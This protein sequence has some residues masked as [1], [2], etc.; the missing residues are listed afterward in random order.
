MPRHSNLNNSHNVDDLSE[1]QLWNEVSA[2]EI[3]RS[4]K[5]LYNFKIGLRK[6]IEKYRSGP[7]TEEDYR[8]AKDPLAVR[9]FKDGR[10]S[11][12]EILDQYIL[13]R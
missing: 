4:T 7:M 5:S 10:N 3:L 2:E 11:W 6:L 8:A 12:A 13:K 9:A 1:D